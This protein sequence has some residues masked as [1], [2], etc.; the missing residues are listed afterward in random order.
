MTSRSSHM[1][2][3][4]SETIKNNFQKMVSVVNPLSLPPPSA[5]PRYNHVSHASVLG[6]QSAR[7][8]NSPETRRKHS[9]PIGSQRSEPFPP[10]RRGRREKRASRIRQRQVNT[11][12]LACSLPIS[13][14]RLC[15]WEEKRNKKKKKKFLSLHYFHYGRCA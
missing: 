10:P 2:K 8:N 9:P 7:E 5:C 14:A 6:C 1:S 12:G 4:A 13:R 15:A 3:V 11:A